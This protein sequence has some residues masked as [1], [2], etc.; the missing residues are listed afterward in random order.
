MQEYPF[1]PPARYGSS[2]FQPAQRQGHH[3]LAD[4]ASFMVAA[5]VSTPPRAAWV[6]AS[7]HA[8]ASVG[9]VCG[10]GA[11]L[12]LLGDGINPANPSPVGLGAIRPVL[13]IRGQRHA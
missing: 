7:I 3:G 13:D 11:R 12:A 2:G 10:F 5:T 8:W 4:L 6:M 9:S 1:P